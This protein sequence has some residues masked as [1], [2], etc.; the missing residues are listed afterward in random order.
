M[1]SGI[2]IE[3]LH[4]WPKLVGAFVYVYYGHLYISLQPHF[5]FLD[6]VGKI[7]KSFSLLGFL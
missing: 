3:L 1:R 4:I 2:P 6:M 5:L 7:G